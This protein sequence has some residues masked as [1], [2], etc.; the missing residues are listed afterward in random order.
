VKA[1]RAS[2]R[3][4]NK[5]A[6][7]SRQ[8]DWLRNC[9]AQ[10][11]AL[12]KNAKRETPENDPGFLFIKS[13]YSLVKVNTAEIQLIEGLKDYIKIQLNGN[14][15]PVLS[16]QSLRSVEE[17]LPASKFCR[18]HKSFIV[19][20]DFVK[21]VQRNHIVSGEREIPIGNQ[22]R[23]SFFALIEGRIPS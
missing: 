14:S 5:T 13:E 20:L 2:T 19:N 11:H 7:I 18:V 1:L 17:K 23:E 21:S 8:G 16:L 6:A 22:Y 9:K 15:K 3:W 4:P 10:E 12:L